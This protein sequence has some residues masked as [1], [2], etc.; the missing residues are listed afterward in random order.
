MLTNSC[1]NAM[2]VNLRLVKIHFGHNGEKITFSIFRIFYRLIMAGL[3]TSDTLYRGL[4]WIRF[5]KI[6]YSQTL[7]PTYLQMH[8]KKLYLSPSLILYTIIINTEVK[9]TST[10]LSDVV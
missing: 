9:L 10:M 2:M 3:K 6:F 1:S 7:T 5:L 4:P 8:N